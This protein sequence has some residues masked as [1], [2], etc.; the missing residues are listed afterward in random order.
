M[1]EGIYGLVGVFI[2]G[3]FILN[4]VGRIELL[5]LDVLFGRLLVCKPLLL[6]YGGKE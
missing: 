5:L 3:S 2:T 4:R 1:S 6:D